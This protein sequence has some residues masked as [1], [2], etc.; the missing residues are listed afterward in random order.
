VSE[1]LRRTSPAAAEISWAREGRVPGWLAR[2]TRVVAPS[3]VAGLGLTL[4]LP[5]F[6]FWILAF[7]AASLLGWRLAGLGWKGRALAGW[8]AGLGQFVPG[9]WWTSGFNVYGA[10]LLMVVE[11]LAPA[12]AC[13]VVPR[14]RGRTG[15]LVGAMVLTEALRGHWPFGGLPLGGAALGQAAGPLAGAARIGGPLVLV[16]MIWAA[17]AG[18]GLMA[19]TSWAWARRERS[20]RRSW[21]ASAKLAPLGA[22]RAR[23]PSKA[24]A[25]FAGGLALAAVTALSWWGSDAPDGGRSVATLRVA[26]VQGGGARGL[27]KAQVDP[28]AVYDAQVAATQTIPEHDGGRPPSLVLWPED[29]V[30]LDDSLSSDPARSALASIAE[31]AHATLV[32]G[33]TETVSTTRFRNEIVAFSPTGKIV[34]TFE[35]VHRVPF[36]EYVPYRGF[37][38]HFASLQGVPLDA[39]P[40]HGDGLLRTPAGPLGAM[41][42]YE[43]FFPERGRLPTRAGA[44][45]LIV[46]T[47]TSSYSTSQVPTQEVAAARLQAISEGRDLVQ[48]APTGFSSIVDNRGRVL[49]RSRLGTRQVLVS[50]VSLRTGRT[51]YE[52]VGDLPVLAGAGVLVLCGWLLGLTE[53]T[54]P[55]S[56]RRERW[57][58]SARS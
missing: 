20:R 43:V 55:E 42:S 14:G 12:I 16:G 34:A 5:P 40:G 58:R 29:V 36:G 9:L 31:Q 39:I 30:A 56:V 52:K 44:E 32:V 38:S 8:V 57:G 2:P 49:E 19:A 21:V 54:T 6:G 25:L 41:V 53:S 15:V 3:L 17:G 4:S 45:L 26:A 22:R 11:S 24:G 33:V 37:F 7:P 48:A 50:D 46:P 27:S 13:A 35:K 10:A 47:N 28:T 18:L 23:V 51:V 1:T